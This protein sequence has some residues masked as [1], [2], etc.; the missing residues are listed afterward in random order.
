MF[1]DCALTKKPISLTKGYYKD[2]FVPKMKDGE[3]EWKFS[4]DGNSFWVDQVAMGDNGKLEHN[5]RIR[6]QI[7]M[8]SAADAEKSKLGSARQEPNHSPFCPPPI[9][10]ISFTLNPFKMFMQM[11]GPSM[12]RKIYCACICL[13]CTALCIYIVPNVIGGLITNLITP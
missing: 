11:V 6:I 13:L 3:K 9:G 10:R 7:D 12:R 1:E 2:Q 8:V 5:G 4:D